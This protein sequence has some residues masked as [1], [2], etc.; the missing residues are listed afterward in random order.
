MSTNT[1]TPRMIIRKLP[2]ELRMHTWSF[3]EFHLVKQCGALLVERQKLSYD[4]RDQTDGAILAFEDVDDLD[5]PEYEPLFGQDEETAAVRQDDMK[6][7]LKNIRLI[8]AE[9]ASVDYERARLEEGIK[10][11]RQMLCPQESSR[12]RI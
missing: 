1:L 6:V 3:V 10:A 11:V 7:H 12:K 4:L 9:M 2:H 5:D 8:E